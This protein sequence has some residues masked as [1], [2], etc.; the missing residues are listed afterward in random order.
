MFISLFRNL[1]QNKWKIARP[2]FLHLSS[3]AQNT[4]CTKVLTLA[5]GLQGLPYDD[6][7]N[8]PLSEMVEGTCATDQLSESSFPY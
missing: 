7:F 3:E 1:Q 8:N 4:V 6:Y 5:S 2:S